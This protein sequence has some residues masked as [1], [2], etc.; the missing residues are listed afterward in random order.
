M[1]TDMSAINVTQVQVL[2]RR[3]RWRGRER[4]EARASERASEER[5]RASEAKARG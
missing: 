4:G 2:V 5:A 1:K 3:G